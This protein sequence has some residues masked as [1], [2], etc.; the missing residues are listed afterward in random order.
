[1]ATVMIRC[2]QTGRAVATGIETEPEDFKRFPRVESRSTC[3][4]C[5]R[6]HVWNVADAFLS[7][8]A[9]QTAA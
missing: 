2:P 6:E 4:A 7:S 3:P 9:E 8:D 1:M 5:G